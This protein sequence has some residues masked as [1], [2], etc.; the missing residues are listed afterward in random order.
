[1]KF[2]IL[3][4][5]N[6]IFYLYGGI[7]RLT[8]RKLTLFQHHALE[9]SLLPFHYIHFQIILVRDIGVISIGH[10]KRIVI[11]INTD[12]ISHLFLILKGLGVRVQLACQ[13]FFCFSFYSVIVHHLDFIDLFVAVRHQFFLTNEIFHGQKLH[14]KGTLIQILEP[15]LKRLIR[16]YFIKKAAHIAICQRKEKLASVQF[17]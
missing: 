7:L 8:Y 9:H 17:C 14:Q 13:I 15:L 16:I 4:V 2:Y 1:M 3:Q 12:G 10:R 6:F 5:C 11:L